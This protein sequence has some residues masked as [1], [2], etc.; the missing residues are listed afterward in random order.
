MA[1]GGG[2]SL[3]SREKVVGRVEREIHRGA[4]KG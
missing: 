4:S 3:R 2:G 1:R